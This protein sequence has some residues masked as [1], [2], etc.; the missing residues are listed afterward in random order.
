MI[1]SINL[2]FPRLKFL[3]VDSLVE[4]KP[5][6]RRFSPRT[7]INIWR[8]LTASVMPQSITSTSLYQSIEAIFL[9]RSQ[10]RTAQSSGSAES[11]LNLIPAGLRYNELWIKCF[12]F[13]LYRLPSLFFLFRL[14]FV[15][16]WMK[17]FDFFLYRLLFLFF[18]FRLFFV[19]S[20]YSYF[21]STSFSLISF[22][23]WPDLLYSSQSI[24]LLCFFVS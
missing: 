19:Y 12:D 22:N 10:E 13:F 18:L 20:F 17:C 21:Y 9:D 16:S 3:L 23:F 8:D 4:L 14:F 6:A 1:S 2:R 11:W 24:L 5:P 7:V 15:Y